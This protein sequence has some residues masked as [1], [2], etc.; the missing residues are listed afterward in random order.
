MIVR[1]M[2]PVLLMAGMIL[3]SLAAAQDLL[4]RVNR[5]TGEMELTGVGETVVN[6]AGY[7]L[8]SSNATLDADPGTFTGLH[9]L[10]SDWV[11]A[12]SQLSTGI[13][14]INSNGNP[15][16]VTAIDSGVSLSLGNVYSPSA[17]QVSGGFG[18]NVELDDLTLYYADTNLGASTTGVIEYYGDGPLNTIGI[19][20]DLETGSAYIENESSFDQTLIGYVIEAATP[21]SLTTSLA[22]FNGL[23]DETEGGNFEPSS[24]LDGE[25][26]GEL[27]PLGTGIAIN[28][29]QSYDLGTIGGLA[30]DL[31]MTFLLAGEGEV[32]R[33]GFVKYVSASASLGDF[34]DDGMVDLADYTVWRNNLGAADESAL[35]FHGDGG[36]V[37]VSDY[38]VWKTNF[39][40]STSA[41]A[42]QQSGVH[43]IPEPSSLGLLGITL[44]GT[45][46]LL[47]RR[48]SHFL[49][50][51]V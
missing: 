4:L 24:L 17:A 36:G 1:T 42:A 16:A 32:T 6:L 5:A 27:D 25:N 37:T 12:G 40:N 9:S 15:S 20:V 48:D 28:A 18:F 45:V 21:G 19:T 35:N 7:Q 39:G 2:V 34:N 22:N 49:N 47:N 33:T 13:G 14:E 44:L 43:A 46:L 8:L 38:Q 31:S 41:L 10:D 26:L 30:D 50:P 23:R 51:R 29:G 11:L 3:P